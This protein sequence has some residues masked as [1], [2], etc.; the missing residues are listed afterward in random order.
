MTK[1]DIIRLQRALRDNVSSE[2][3][4]DGIWGKQSNAF[5]YRYATINGLDTEQARE[6]L[7]QYAEARYVTDKAFTQAAK[8]LGVPESYVRAIAEVETSGDS[9]LK[10]GS[11]KILFERHWFHRKLGEALKKSEVRKHIASFLNVQEPVSRDAPAILL[12]LVEKQYRSICSTIRGSY[13]GGEAEW[14]RLNLAMDIN[15]EAAC[16][17]ASYGGYQLMGF[18]H[19]AC[20]YKTAKDMMLALAKSES[21]QFL[22]M[23]S[24]IKANRG[25]HEALRLGNWTRFAE[26]YNGPAYTEN[27]YNTKLAKAE[28]AWAK[29]ILA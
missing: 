9:F 12:S 22:A 23:I 8:S 4:V 27:A 26:L 1:S 24:F 6:L 5:L 25:M 3:L 19:A 29:K 28:K 17:S 14:G 10:S 11:M 13:L 2:I 18:N 15:I 16:M 20:G 7:F 21:T